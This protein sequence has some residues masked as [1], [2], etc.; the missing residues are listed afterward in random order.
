MTRLELS[1]SGETIDLNSI[2][3]TDEGVQAIEG[4]TGFGLPPVSPQWVEGA[5][6]GATYRG[7]RVAQRDI[8]LPLHIVA[9]ERE[10]LK[11]SVQQLSRVLADR[12]TLTW[13]DENGYE[14]WY[15]DC[16][17]VGGG[18]YV[19]GDDTTG[20]RTLDLVIT[21]RTES[22]YWTQNKVL[23]VEHTGSSIPSSLE[24][25]NPGSA[26]AQP[27]WTVTGPAVRFVATAPDGRELRYERLIMTDEIL[28]FD[29]EKGTVTDGNG[30]NRYNGLAD[31]PRFFELK[32]GMNNVGIQLIRDQAEFNEILGER[33]F[34]YVLNP[35]FETDISNWTPDVADPF[36]VQYTPERKALTF[37]G[38]GSKTF[39]PTR[40][41]ASTTVTG[42]TP[43]GSYNLRVWAA[44]AGRASPFTTGTR[45]NC[46]VRCG[47]RVYGLGNIP[48]ETTDISINI[49]S[50]ED[51]TAIIT[52][53][54]PNRPTTY[55]RE[56]YW[57]LEGQW[58]IERVYFGEDID[59][60]DG[61]T[62]D[63]PEALYYWEDLPHAS[64]S[65]RQNTVE[66]DTSG[67]QVKVSYRPRDWMVV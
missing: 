4:L 49:P 60:F 5:G 43:G 19:Y 50:A 6:D 53:Y 24:L 54:G 40:S 57:Y 65:V 51:S 10:V 13:Y 25:E 32:P 33:Q 38:S 16:Y 64:R 44:V 48:M 17:R 59:Y 12:C 45:W 41:T 21:L 18:D 27:I 9:P 63:T 52:I 47:D 34:N 8:D 56:R 42:L 28:T 58:D 61:E 1:G 37:R 55:K 15:V 62:L 14:S 22:P 29:T 46:N 11:K 36:Y 7:K 3:E 20:E 23:E 66:L 39:V 67:S 26:T 2:M 30:N 31:A 35:T